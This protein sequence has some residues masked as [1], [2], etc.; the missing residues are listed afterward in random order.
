ME[1]AWQVSARQAAWMAGNQKQFLKAMLEFSG[2]QSVPF[3]A[4]CV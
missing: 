1:G 4:R 3:L 2:G